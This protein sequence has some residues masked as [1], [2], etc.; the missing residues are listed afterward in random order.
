MTITQ[1]IQTSPI[2]ANEL[3]GKL[4]DTSDGAVKTRERLFAELKGEMETLAEIEEKHLFPALRKHQE[5]KQLVADAVSD[6]K[7]VRKLLSE[8]DDLDKGNPEFASKL[9]ELRKVFQSH[10]RDE[11]KELLP[12]VRKALSG[13]EIQAV[14][15]KIESARA[16]AQTE[17]RA[18]A[19]ERRTE[20]KSGNGAAG[21]AAAEGS[22][23]KLADAAAGM[24]R[25]SGEASRRALDASAE[26][27]GKAAQAAGTSAA[28]TVQATGEIAD[29][30][31]ASKGAE[32]VSRASEEM[33][34]AAV[35]ATQEIT[36][37]ATE[38]ATGG[39]E[40][41]SQVTGK[42]AEAAGHAAQNT[43]RVVQAGS[44]AAKSAG[45]TVAESA[46][47]MADLGTGQADRIASTAV[48]TVRAANDAFQPAFRGLEALSKLPKSSLEAVQDAAEVWSDLAKRNFESSARASREMLS[49]RSPQQIVEA[50]G[51]LTAE[52]LQSW[53]EAGTR[54]M[55]ISIQASRGIKSATEKAAREVERR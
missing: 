34:Q 39:S 3:F 8:L 28:S 47:Q 41:L 2:K 9:T 42:M 16:D 32:T 7:Q 5:T 30:A 51:R 19:K 38:A 35:Q 54:L 50:Q 4:A 23:R 55:N 43:L 14:V 52:L 46:Q 45:E 33:S 10:I 6:N 29:A 31:S 25:A 26:A 27:T 1:L 49:L 15:E 17:K 12:A 18:E 36:G 22:A 11:K 40:A 53:I 20:A 13:E 44:E 37:A 21:G 48:D 24:T